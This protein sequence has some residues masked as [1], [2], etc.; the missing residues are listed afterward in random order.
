MALRSVHS[1]LVKTT[2]GAVIR[3]LGKGLFHH[4][5]L[6][7]ITSFTLEA[8]HRQIRISF[9]PAQAATLLSTTL[10]RLSNSMDSYVIKT[11]TA[12]ARPGKMAAPYTVR[13]EPMLEHRRS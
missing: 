11:S 9:T 3:D 5:H 12:K 8:V 2:T 7:H 10:C 13:P 6:R 4:R 1:G